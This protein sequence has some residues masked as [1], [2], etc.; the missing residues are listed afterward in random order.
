MSKDSLL[1]TKVLHTSDKLPSLVVLFLIKY[2]GVPF[3]FMRKGFRVSLHSRYTPTLGECLLK[4]VLVL[5]Y[6]VRRYSR[7]LSFTYVLHYRY[8]LILGWGTSNDP[9]DTDNFPYKESNRYVKY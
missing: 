3:M 4:L 7:C 1:K 6:L 2:Y 5:P 9:V 8:F